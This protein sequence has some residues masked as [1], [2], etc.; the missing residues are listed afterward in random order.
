MN[1][2]GGARLVTS[3]ALASR[4]IAIFFIRLYSFATLV[5]IG[6]EYVSSLTGGGRG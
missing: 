4:I 5:S 2:V 3:K 1:W 6:A